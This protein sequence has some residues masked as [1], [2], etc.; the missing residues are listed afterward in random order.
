MK[1]YLLIAVSVALL[2]AIIR[3][4]NTTES[5]ADYYE[6]LSNHREGILEFMNNS[7]KSPFA[8]FPDSV[9]QLQYFPVDEKYKVQAKIE[10]INKSTYLTL[11][12]SD[13]SS[14][15]YRKYAY[16]HFELGDTPLKLLVLKSTDRKNAPLTIA[17]SD[18]TSGEETYG[19]GRYLDVD[20]KR[21]KR[22]TLDFNK[23]Y[24]PYCVYNASYICPLPTRENNLKAYIKAGEKMF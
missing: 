8:S 12:N 3:S 9:I 20:F 7:A 14:T 15:E 19:G 5:T 17:F 21:A 23:A 18:L 11:G 2:V 6:H 22:I 16:A 1:K 10:L 4:L 24:N 13:G